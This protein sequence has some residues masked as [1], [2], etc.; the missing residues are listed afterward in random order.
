MSYSQL[1]NLI[2]TNPTAFD[3]NDK[4]PKY[5]Y[6]YKGT[7]F[8]IISAA[9]YEAMEATTNDMI[10]DGLKKGKSLADQ[11]KDYIAALDEIRKVLNEGAKLPCLPENSPICVL[12][13][14]FNTP[15]IQLLGRWILCV[16]ALK[17]LKKIKGKG[18]NGVLVITPK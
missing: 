4:R 14:H 7:A 18:L 3:K 2:K 15:H 5:L 10:E 8:P 1:N 12:E 9:P 6:F 13:R 17:R 11:T 16:C